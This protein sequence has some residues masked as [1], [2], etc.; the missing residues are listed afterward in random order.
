[1]GSQWGFFFKTFHKSHKREQWRT[2]SSF[3]RFRTAS[4]FFSSKILLRFPHFPSH[5]LSLFPSS[6]FRSPPWSGDTSPSPA[7]GGTGTS[8]THSGKCN[9][10]IHQNEL[11]KLARIAC[12]KV[13]CSL[14]ELGAKRTRN[15]LFVEWP[16]HLFLS[17]IQG[18]ISGEFFIAQLSLFRLPGFSICIPDEGEGSKC[19]KEEEGGRDRGEKVPGGKIMRAHELATLR[20]WKLRK[21]HREEKI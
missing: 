13:I 4:S 12:F 10:T 17:S 1:M 3:P 9:R 19:G 16:P 8:H 20:R 7:R 6:I 21:Q 11:A 2:I 18:A 15:E 5:L 14:K